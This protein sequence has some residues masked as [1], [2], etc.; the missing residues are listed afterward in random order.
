MCCCNVDNFM[1]K[2]F[3]KF[4]FTNNEGL[5]YI[6]LLRLGPSLA[7][8]IS[9][10]TGIKRVTVY[11]CLKNLE[12]EQFVDSFLSN[13]VTYFR[14]A[15]PN[16]FLK[17]CRAREIY[18]RTLNE[19]VKTVLPSLLKLEQEQS[20]PVNETLIE[21][22]KEQLCFGLNQYHQHVEDEWKRYTSK[23]VALG[24]KVLSIQPKT[25][26]AQ[27]YKGRDSSEFRKTKLVPFP[28]FGSPCELNIIGDMV[29]I[30]MP[31]GDQPFGIKIYNKDIAKTLQSL[32][33]LAWESA[34]K[35]DKKMSK[36]D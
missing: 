21:D 34:D 31:H 36:K 10:R 18:L 14:S 2:I 19:E 27:A 4:G 22:C 17:S 9:K 12:K 30:F 23:R 13:D 16:Q 15:S 29:A 8:T 3:K 25:K 20:K 7:S 24:M 11:A 35:Y 28:S 1:Q 26:I 6:H 5:I 32:F 33:K